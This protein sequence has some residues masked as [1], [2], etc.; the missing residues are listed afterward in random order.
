VAEDGQF[1]R[2]RL[3]ERLGVGG[4]GEVWHARLESS[5]GIETS[6]V[7]KRV[8]PEYATDPAFI[9]MLAAEARVCARLDHPAIVKVYEFGEVA[10]QYYLAMEMV[11]GW[12]LGNV[13]DAFASSGRLPPVELVCH[14]G[15]ELADALA[16]AHTLTDDRGHPYGLVHRDITPGNVMIT[17]QGAIKLVDFGVHTIRD[18]RAEERTATGT[19]RGTISYMSPEQADG[20]Q[21]DHR[22]DVFSL[23]VLL[24]EALTGHQMFRS[25]FPLETLR[26]VREAEVAPPSSLRAGLDP[27]LDRLLLAMLA[28]SPADRC[29]SCD[30]VGR[31][32]RPLAHAAGVDAAAVRALLGGLP[33]TGGET[34]RG[35]ERAATQPQPLSPS[36]GRRAWLIAALITAGI[37]LPYAIPMPSQPPAAAPAVP[38]VDAGL[39]PDGP[40]R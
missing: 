36:R 18:R 29:A 5:R 10:G 7:L 33:L 11:D 1:G 6:L 12:N 16:Y 9:A 39:T 28:R 21:V 14:L 30:E 8:R 17:R 40:S 23:G 22:S 20:R 2:F 13:L 34:I 15:A 25:A 38:V 37:A 31:T 19:L 32:L 3:I 35:R 4:M 24:Y 26:R 27:R